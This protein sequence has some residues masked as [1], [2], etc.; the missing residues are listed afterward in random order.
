[1]GQL[2]LFTYRNE[3]VT[4][5]PRYSLLF[6]LDI[7]SPGLIILGNTKKVIISLILFSMMTSGETQTKTP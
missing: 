3:L 4:A 5:V 7:A 2:P 1:M 6:V